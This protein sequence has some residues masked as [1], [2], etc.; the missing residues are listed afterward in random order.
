MLTPEELYEGLPKEA[1]TR[2]RKEAAK[3]YGQEAV[4]RSEQALRNMSKAD[5]QS[6]KN[7]Q[8]EIMSALLK[9][10]NE[11]PAAEAVQA[12]I[13]RHYQNIRCF[14]GT[15]GSPEPQA[16]QYAGLGRLYLDDERFTSVNGQPQP[17]LAKLMSAAIAHFAQQLK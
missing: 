4:E 15:S 5:F 3:A 6:L 12:L 9:L 2:W 17:A 1:L 10:V 11:A 7:E 16:E 8:Q 13:G 14:W